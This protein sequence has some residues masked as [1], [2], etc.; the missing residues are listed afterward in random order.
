MHGT[1]TFMGGPDRGDTACLHNLSY[2]KVIAFAGSCHRPGLGR[3]IYSV[4][5]EAVSLNLEKQVSMLSSESS[6][7]I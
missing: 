7:K 6:D 2:S 4:S 5:I 3:D 1:F